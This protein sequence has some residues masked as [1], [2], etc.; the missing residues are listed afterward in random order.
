MYAP[1]RGRAGPVAKTHRGLY[2]RTAIPEEVTA[3]SPSESREV[4]VR[5]RGLTLFER[6]SLAIFSFLVMGTLVVFI[7]SI[8]Y[9]DLPAATLSAALVVPYPGFV[10]KVVLGPEFGDSGPSLRMTGPYRTKS[11]E[12]LR[13]LGKPTR[14][15]S[16]ILDP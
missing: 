2:G 7:G 13:D 4:V 6:M 16:E 11:S 10:L 5:F 3:P 15:L 8:T 9:H 14:P 1:T 12:N